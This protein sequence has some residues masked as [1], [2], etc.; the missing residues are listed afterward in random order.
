MAP[1]KS[2]KIESREQKFDGITHDSQAAVVVPSFFFCVQTQYKSFQF[3]I[4]RTLAKSCQNKTLSS[5]FMHMHLY[6][7]YRFKC[8]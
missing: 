4:G 2:D 8:R 1:F 5:H 3:E 6:M 7:G